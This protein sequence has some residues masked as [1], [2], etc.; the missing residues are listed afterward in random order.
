MD[1]GGYGVAWGDVVCLGKADKCD[2]QWQVGVFFRVSKVDGS[3][4]F[5]LEVPGVEWRVIGVIVTDVLKWLAGVE[6]V[7][8][9]FMGFVANRASVVSRQVCG[10]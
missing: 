4:G 2:I 6:E 3:V 8:V 10:L 9:G 5:V 7:V 1:E